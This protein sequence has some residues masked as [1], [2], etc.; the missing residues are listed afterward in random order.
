LHFVKAEDMNRFLR[1]RQKQFLMG[2]LNFKVQKNCAIIGK[3]PSSGLLQPVLPSAS[4]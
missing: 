1:K 4:L 2:A 3:I